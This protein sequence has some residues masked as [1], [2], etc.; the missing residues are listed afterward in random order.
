[1]NDYRR[2]YVVIRRSG[3]CEIERWRFFFR[4]QLMMLL[5]YLGGDGLLIKDP[6]D[7]VFTAGE[8]QC[9]I[10]LNGTEERLIATNFQ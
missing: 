3:Y 4:R 8:D 7:G 2:V 9:I 10:F 6:L 1:M 5:S